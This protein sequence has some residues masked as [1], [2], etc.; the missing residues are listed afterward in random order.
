VLLLLLQPKTLIGHQLVV[1]LQ[2]ETVVGQRLGLLLVQSNTVIGL[3]GQ[4]ADRKAD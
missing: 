4:W 1:L 3:G 2:S